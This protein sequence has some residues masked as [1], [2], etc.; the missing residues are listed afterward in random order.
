VCDCPRISR[1]CRSIKCTDPNVL[2]AARRTPCR[3]TDNHGLAFAPVQPADP[4]L[5]DH[6]RSSYGRD[7]WLRRC[8]GFLVETATRRIGRVTGIRYSVDTNEPDVIEVRAGLF[9]RTVLLISVNDIAEIL[10]KERLVMLPGPPRPL[11][12]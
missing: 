7:Y 6:T 1:G 4:E 3:Q 8:E 12:G 9:G 11:S 10:P 2:P 5:N